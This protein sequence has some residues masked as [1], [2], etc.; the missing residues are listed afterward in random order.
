M[1]NLFAL[2][3]TH[4]RAMDNEAIFHPTACCLL[5]RKT[6]P[7]RAGMIRVFLAFGPLKMAGGAAVP[8]LHRS[9]WRWGRLLTCRFR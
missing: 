3:L 1:S 4:A 7:G 9:R 5:P 2:V 6:I 8:V